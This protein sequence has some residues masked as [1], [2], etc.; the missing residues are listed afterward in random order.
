[1]TLE[2]IKQVYGAEFTRGQRVKAL[3]QSGIVTGATN[4]VLVRLDGHKY[5]TPY[6]PTDVKA[7]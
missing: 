4:H 7:Q 3:G 6:H 2:Y 1:M 5:P